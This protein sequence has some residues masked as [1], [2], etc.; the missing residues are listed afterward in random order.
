[1]EDIVIIKKLEAFGVGPIEANIYLFLCGKPA[2]TVLSMSRELNIPRTTIYDSVLN[3]IDLGLIERI[4]EYRT[5][6]F[7]A[8]PIDILQSVID[9]QKTTAEQLSQDLAFLKTQ[10]QTPIDQTIHTEVRY[11]HGAEGFRQ[12]M[13]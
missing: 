9:Q 1:M 6:R 8:Y 5:Q 12:M 11:Y 10:L 2:Q 4:V 7:K 3:L 13:S